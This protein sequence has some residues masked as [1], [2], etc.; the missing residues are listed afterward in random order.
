VVERLKVPA[1]RKAG[2][3]TRRALVEGRRYLIEVSGTYRYDRGP[4]SLADAEC[5]TRDGASWW[6]RER[7]LRHDEWYADHL[8]LYVDGHDL[9]AE[10]DD[11]QSC[12]SEGH[13][14][15]WVYEA[16]RTGRVPFALWDPDGFG[17][18]S[19]KLSVQVLDLGAHRDTM[20]WKVPAR[21]RA[22]ATSPGLLR[23]G[24][25]YQVTVS[26]TWSNG[27]GV[28]SDAEC[29]IGWGSTW[30]RDVDSYDMVTGDWSYDS[31]APRLSGVRSEP[32]SGAPECD[33]DHRYTY[34]FRPERTTPLNIRVGDPGGHAD[35]TGALTVVVR[36]Y[37]ASAPAPAPSPAPG[38][39]PDPVP[40]PTPAPEP[41]PEPTPE[42]EEPPLPLPAPR[43]AF[44]PERLWVDS[45]S[46]EPVRTEQE[47][48]AGTTLRV[49]A[50][51]MYFMRQSGDH[52]IVAD[53]EC[54]VTSWDRRWQPTRFEGEFDGRTAPLGDLVVNG[55]IVTWAPSD[56]R[57]SCDSGE[58]TYT[59]DVTLAQG[60]PLWLVVADDD[61]GDNRGA[62]EVEVT[63]R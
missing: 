18:N 13:T 29:S 34:V 59:Y 60:G 21:S 31:L 48:P 43:P 14:Y 62:L 20:S 52:W 38:P 3:R 58:H 47:Y 23:G 8:D 57:G 55:E 4:A 22:G 27:E 56:G 30:R 50:T 28:T 41:T 37:D 40:E 10:S 45:R 36:P 9:Y 12:D 7:S 24:E 39:S 53:A 44:D 26:G 17:D 63:V 46:A 19:G 33:D 51:G 1:R 15:R 61:Y 16:E 49:T 35:N 2:T 32:V 11:G 6:Q 54:T 42:P 5:S 25:E